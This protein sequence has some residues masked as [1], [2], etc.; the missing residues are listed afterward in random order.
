LPQ[1]YSYPGVYIEEIPSG[2]RTIVGVPTSVVAFVGRTQRGPVR[3]PKE[4]F[5]FP[6]FER[7]F[8]GLWSQSSLSY[9][10]RDF[11]LNSGGG[12][13]VIVRTPVTE[14]V[15]GG[16][17]TKDATATISLDKLDL[18]ASSPGVWGNALR[19]KIDYVDLTAAD[20]TAKHF[21]LTITEVD[22]DGR[23][24]TQETFKRLSINES[25]P[26]R[27]DAVLASSSRLARLRT[28]FALNGDRPEVTTIADADK[29]KVGNAATAGLDATHGLS[30]T[31]IV[32]GLQALDKADIFNLLC[33]PPLDAP[34]HDDTGLTSGIVDAAITACERARAML[35]LDPP[36]TWDSHDK[37]Q[38]GLTA[39]GWATSKNAALYFPRIRKTDPTLAD[40]KI[41]VDFA[42]C[43][44]V[45]GVFARTD[46][47][48]GVWKAPAG[49]DAVLRGAPKLSVSLTDDQ[50]GVLNPLGINCL[51]VK[52]GPA[53]VVWGARTR[54][55][56]DALASEWKYVPVR[57]LANFIEETLFRN[58]QWVVFEPNDEPLWAS[59]RLNV[60]S[61]MHSLFREGAFQGGTPRDAYLVKCDKDTT[62]QDDI[63]RGIVNI[64]VG[65]APLKPAEFVII[66]VQ[67]IAGSIDT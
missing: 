66:K 36:K 20:A 34:I 7:E 30:Q 24:V 10:V 42:P 19:A 13:I 28:T 51:R 46:G 17:A 1:A 3:E 56:A 52:P 4:I 44:A 35:I 9:A 55:G 15:A 45:A 5:S 21:N 23:I 11:Y 58:T 29:L 2:V 31:E 48:R 14:A 8:G 60:G 39:L 26:R 16:D 49:L 38:T 32:A 63:D 41:E 22:A 33:I 12:R 25:S 62:T 43:G 65:F 50:N 67:Q 57:R 27:I 61:F 59:I 64:V 18:E 6:E 40:G 53:R 37:A 47:E 54:V